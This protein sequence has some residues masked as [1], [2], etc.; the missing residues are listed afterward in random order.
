MARGKGEEKRGKEEEEGEYT[1]SYAHHTR[2]VA[3]A[4]PNTIIDYSDDDE[5]DENDDTSAWKGDSQ[6][7]KG[8][9]SG[10]MIMAPAF[11]VPV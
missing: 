7:G 3:V 9:G 8:S 1:N 11:S 4:P 2:L 6:R 5:D 10:G